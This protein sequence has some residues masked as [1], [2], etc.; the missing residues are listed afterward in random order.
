[1]LG[2]AITAWVVCATSVGAQ[3]T[4]GTAGKPAVRAADSVTVNADRGL[5]GVSDSATSVAVVSQQ[6]MKAEPGLTLDDRAASGG[7]VSVV[8]EDEFVDGES[9]DGGR[10][11]AGA[12]D[13]RRLAGRWW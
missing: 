9:Y 2:W 11:F 4:G 6:K 10:E 13:R 5:V 7:G 1:M 8:S 12:G 3:E